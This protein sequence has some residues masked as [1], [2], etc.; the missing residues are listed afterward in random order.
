MSGANAVIGCSD[1][2]VFAAGS[3]RRFNIKELPSRCKDTC[4]RVK[5][6][7]ARFS[8]GRDGTVYD[9]FNYCK[10][11]E[12]FFT[13]DVNVVSVIGRLLCPCC[14][15]PLRTRRRHDYAN[16]PSGQRYREYVKLLQ[17][18]PGIK[19]QN[20]PVETVESNSNGHLVV[21]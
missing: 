5:A 15:A 16:S 8:R 7:F 9:H 14:R 19:C 1:Y 6:T 12:A 11:C 4:R 21:A 13:K 20:Q 18:V 2:M 3:E 10:V 17:T